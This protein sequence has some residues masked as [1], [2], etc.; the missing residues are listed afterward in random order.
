MP[1]FTFLR[2]T[3]QLSVANKI[4]P[5]SSWKKLVGKKTLE[6]QPYLELKRI[7]TES[8]PQSKELLSLIENIHRS[9]QVACVE[10]S[11]ISFDCFEKCYWSYHQQISKTTLTIWFCFLILLD[12]L[13]CKHSRYWSVLLIHENEIISVYFVKQFVYGEFAQ[14]NDPK[15]NLIHAVSSPNH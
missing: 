7:Y 8:S 12:L 11:P 13:H 9:S 15:W 6:A 10:T 3:K 5:N 2:F 4:C 14:Y 1:F